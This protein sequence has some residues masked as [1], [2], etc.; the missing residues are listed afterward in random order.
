M[1]ALI[2]LNIDTFFKEVDNNNRC[3]RA[4]KRRRLHREYKCEG[5]CGKENCDYITA[6][7]DDYN[8]HIRQVKLQC[9]S[10][11]K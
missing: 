3:I 2:Q 8:G 11:I 7:R 4:F 5:Q 6:Y 10:C 9:P 1:A